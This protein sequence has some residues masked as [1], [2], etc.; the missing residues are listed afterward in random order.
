MWWLCALVAK[1]TCLST[2]HVSATPT[3]FPWRFQGRVWFRPALVRAPAV[4]S[5]P[6]GVRVLRA[7][8]W[9]LGGCVAL[10]YDES[11]IA[12]TPSYLEYVTMSAA[13]FKR[14]AI[15][16]WGSRLFVSTPNAA[17]ENRAIWGVP[18]EEAHIC[19][20]EEGAQLAVNAAPPLV[21]GEKP[22]IRVDGWALT[23][24]AATEA[25]S[26]GQ[27]PVM[28]TPQLKALWTPFV[29]GSVEATQPLQTRMLRL[30]GK[31]IRLH[32]CPQASSKQLGLPLPAGLSVDGV[33]IE[34]GD[35]C[36]EDL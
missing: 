29:I 28:W 26:V 36:G 16:L 10:Q 9:T 7:L 22:M 25:Q 18:A 11:P 32:W 2:S 27:L 3:N 5:L 31:S 8:G 14:G 35:P 20:A 15:G 1:T 30:S 23:R 13:V 34:I 12:A 21:G 4:G 33:V 24:N 6:A 19:F 17:M